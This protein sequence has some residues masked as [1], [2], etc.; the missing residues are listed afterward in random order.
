MVLESLALMLQLLRLPRLAA[1]RYDAISALLQGSDLC[2][3]PSDWPLPAEPDSRSRLSSLRRCAA[4]LLEYDIGATRTRVLR[5]K[6]SAAELARYVLAR[7]MALLADPAER[8]RRL[9]T[10]VLRVQGQLAARQGEP[11]LSSECLAAFFGLAVAL[12]VWAATETER[13]LSPCLL[14]FSLEAMRRLGQEFS[15]RPQ[16]PPSAGQWKA[17][18]DAAEGL[19]LLQGPSPASALSLAVGEAAISL[20]WRRVGMVVSIK[21][22]EMLEPGHHVTVA[23]ATILSHIEDAAWPLVR[24][25]ALFAILRGSVVGSSQHL[26]AALM[27]NDP[28]LIQQA[29]QG[30]RCSE[31]C[32]ASAL[33]V[34][35]PTVLPMQPCFQ[36]MAKDETP[37]EVKADGPWAFDLVIFSSCPVPLVVNTVEVLYEDV[38]G[39]LTRFWAENPQRIL[40]GNNTIP[41]ESKDPV[42]PGRYLA[43]TVR[44]CAGLLELQELAPLIPDMVVRGGEAAHQH[45]GCEVKLSVLRAR[46]PYVQLLLTNA[47]TETTWVVRKLQLAWAFHSEPPLKN[48]NC[49]L[50]PGGSVLLAVRGGGESGASVIVSLA[51]QGSSAGV[52]LVKQLPQVL[53]PL[54]K[55]DGEAAKLEVRL[56]SQIPAAPSPGLQFALDFKLAAEDGAPYKVMVRG[57]KAWKAIGRNSQWVRDNQPFTL[58]FLAIDTET[59]ELPY[60]LVKTLTLMRFSPCFKRAL[61]S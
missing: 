25:R 46:P 13:R 32:L 45:E 20:G 9:L 31:D 16:S 29:P 55:L 1:E 54:P 39:H 3:P 14:L 36:A 24:R 8:T 7:Q 58:R 21:A 50:K 5:N 51:K 28:A 19:V 53:N 52:D 43:T 10:F 34:T 60:I 30:L 56:L 17:I 40:V 59:T 6:I 15:G 23:I 44:V 48:M 18:L 26:S 47:S 33:A 12:E 42:L 4:E 61:G 22:A 38:E 35:A 37:L 49:E 41:V 57:E 2:L 11:G 27:L